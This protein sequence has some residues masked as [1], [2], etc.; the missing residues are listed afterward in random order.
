MHPETGSYLGFAT[1]RYRDSKRPDRPP[2]SA[3]EA[4][5]RAVRTRGIKVDADIVRVEYDAE[6]RRSR[7]ML[8]EHLKREKEKRNKS[9]LLLQPRLLRL[10]PN[11]ELLLSSLD[12]PQ[13]L[14]R[15]PQHS[16][17]L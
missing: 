17:N 2:V 13:P 15:V 16:D 9:D 10:A 11:L 14:L 5:R 6:G 4:A 12:L 8:E 1:I 3:M 7:R